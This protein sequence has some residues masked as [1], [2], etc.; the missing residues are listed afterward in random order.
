MK[1]FEWM[2]NVGLCEAQPGL[3]GNPFLWLE[4]R[5]QKDWERKTDKLP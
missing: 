4:K 1:K 5:G 3:S 2:T